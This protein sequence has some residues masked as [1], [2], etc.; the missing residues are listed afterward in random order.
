MGEKCYSNYDFSLNTALRE[1]RYKLLHRWHVITPAL[2]SK[3]YPG[4]FQSCRR[5]GFR[6]TS[7]MRLVDMLK[8]EEILAGLAWRNSGRFGYS[9]TIYPWSSA[10]RLI[11]HIKHRR[12]LINLVTT[13]SILLAKTWKQENT[14]PL[15]EWRVQVYFIRFMSKLTTFHRLLAAGSIKAMENFRNQWPSFIVSVVPEMDQLL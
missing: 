2:L 12:V 5:C 11:W 1:H 6:N 15:R 3:Y 9:G 10:S 14:P 8:S 7:W 4:S 13:A